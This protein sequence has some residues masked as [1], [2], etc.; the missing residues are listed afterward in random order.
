MSDTIDV[1]VEAAQSLRPGD[2]IPEFRLKTQRDSMTSLAAQALGKSV[3]L[4]FCGDLNGKA[5]DGFLSE[6]LP[7]Y[8]RASQTAHFIFLTREVPSAT[9]VFSERLNFPFPVMTDSDGS[10]FAAYGVPSGGDDGLT[11]VLADANR[12][13]LRIDLDCGGAGYAS[14][15]LQDLSALP[16]AVP[17]E[18]GRTAPVLYVARVLDPSFCQELIRH[19]ETQGHRDSEV[20]H[21]QD[22]GQEQELVNYGTK[23]RSDHLIGDPEIG[24]RIGRDLKARVL[25]EIQK[26]FHYR[27]TG[28][29][30]LKIGCYEADR[31]GFF[32]PHRD[33]TAPRVAHRR[34]A[35]TLNLNT[36]E[37]EGGHLRFPEYGPHL[38]RP[39]AGD[40]VI[41]SC[42]LVHEVLPVTAGR[43]FALISFFHGADADA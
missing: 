27:V 18:V 6:L 15:M 4:V 3:V 23:I 26:A 40:A 11:C 9:A 28:L 42:S 7:Q 24:G 14:Q 41:F 36:G 34:F 16:Q 22:A 5:L 30:W 29:D 33:D 1:K 31:Q 2:R 12:Q 43:R 20:M 13:L 38:Y 32:A 37:Y 10:V 21:G 17:L 8:E 25:P 19:F 39:A 35:M